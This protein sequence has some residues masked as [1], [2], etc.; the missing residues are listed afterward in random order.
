MPGRRVDSP[1]VR[2]LVFHGYLLRGT[3][4]NVY[5][6]ELAET[7]V[8]LGHDVHLLCQEREPAGLGFV[9]SIGDWEGGKLVVR[10]V[11]HAAHEG[12]CTVYRPDIAGLLPVY[13]YDRYEGFEVRTFD[14]LSDSELDRYLDANVG[15]VRAV[16]EA[17]DPDVALANHLVMGPVILARALDDVPYAAKIHGSALEYTVKPHYPRFAPFAREGLA[18]ARAVLVGSRHTAESLWTAMAIE[19]LPER[20][21]LGPPGVDTHTFAPRSKGEWRDTIDGL[22]R[23]LETAT[24]TGFDARAAAALDELSAP[25][26]ETPPDAAAL[27]AVR[28]EYDPSGIDLDAPMTL[29]SI[30]PVREPVVCFVGKLIVSKGPDLLLAAWPLVLA[31][32]PQ[33]RLV[34]VGFGTY[35]EGLELL[36]RALERA[37]EDLL[38][39]I[40]RYGRAF[41][42]GERSQLTYLRAFLEGL[43]GRSERYFAAARRMRE[44]IVF[45]GRLEH[46]VL[47]RLL[48]AA[49]SVV[50]PSMF[51]EAF[52]MVAAEAAACGAL[53]VSAAHSGLA[54]VTAILAQGLSRDITPLLSFERGMRAVDGIADALNGWLAIDE[55]TR[56][57]ARAQLARTAR[58]HFSWEKVAESVLSA[59]RG[60]LDLLDTVPGGPPFA[61]S[62]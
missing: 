55:A 9:D 51:P 34:L 60:R 5:N 26:R 33:A 45:T 57:E 42:G 21:R 27:E 40:I 50:M 49:Q 17:V 7:L 32:N 15:A 16:A 14:Q 53:P 47:A 20:T 24:R 54:E 58:E 6:A 29:A 44:S 62:V 38:S 23:W 37:D 52:G 35:R 1:A 19:H 25:T 46:G 3:G 30:D 43:D 13:V 18:K 8:R 12:S 56:E 28:A 59:A 2:V 48:P 41:E 4:S 31:R 36:I 22:V 10:T 11:A 61:P 39:R